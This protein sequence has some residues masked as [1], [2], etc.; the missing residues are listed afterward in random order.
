MDSN[1]HTYEGLL[2]LAR[3]LN[4]EGRMSLAEKWAKMADHYAKDAAEMKSSGNK[5]SSDRMSS[6]SDAYKE[7]SVKMKTLAESND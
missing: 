1:S 5:E 7:A 2:R 3:H 6:F 4:K